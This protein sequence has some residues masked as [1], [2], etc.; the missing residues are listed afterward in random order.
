MEA[1]YGIEWDGPYSFDDLQTARERI[2]APQVQLR[3]HLTEEDL[4]R[5]PDPDVPFLD[6]V[7]VYTATLQ[8]LL[9]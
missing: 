8:Q 4:A 7:N 5:S 2:E 9:H 1:D 6:A 3:H